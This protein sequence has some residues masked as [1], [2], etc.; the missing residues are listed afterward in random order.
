MFISDEYYGSMSANEL[1]CP[2]KV[3]GPSGKTV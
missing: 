3:T 2:Q 1:L